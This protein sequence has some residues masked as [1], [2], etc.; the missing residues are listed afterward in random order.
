M[1][2]GIYRFWMKTRLRRWYW[3]AIR[4]GGQ[5]LEYVGEPVEKLTGFLIAVVVMAFYLGVVNLILMFVSYAVLSSNV[6]AY[7][8]SL[9]GVVPVIFYARYRARRYVLARTRWLGVRF[10][11]QPGAWG[12]TGR[13]IWHWALA[14]LT[15]GLLW[16]R[17]TFWLE[18]Y[19][20]DRTTFGD[21][22]L[23]QGG[24]WRMLVPAMA[25]VLAGAGLSGLFVLVA[26][27]GEPRFGFL[28]CAS[29]PWAIY[30]LVHYTVVAKRTLADHKTAGKV[31]L[32]SR[33]RPGRIARIYAMGYG[34]LIG[35][36]LVP[37]VGLTVYL[38]RAGIESP[39]EIQ[40][41]VGGAPSAAATALGVVIYFAAFLYWAVLRQVLITLP[42]MR[43]YA[44][45][46]TITGA[47][48]I[49]GIRQRARDDFAEAEGFAEALD[50]GAAI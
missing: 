31:G 4:P 39:E 2:L 36:F 42:V 50:L 3:S 7:V 32:V 21:A 17:R 18:K 46:L 29:V 8:A 43:H 11:L 28:L 25:H 9:L 15:L 49:A 13:A 27:A 5:P 22:V 44:R 33:A 20:T 38:A 35:T 30:G 16:P 26:V 40:T 10:G 12:Y 19:I 48:A 37:I 45:T 6:A 1:T 24:D 34:V 47:P 23:H 41:I 14:I